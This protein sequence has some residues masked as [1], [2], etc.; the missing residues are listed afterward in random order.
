MEFPKIVLITKN[1]PWN[2]ALFSSGYLPPIPLLERGVHLKGL[3]KH[4]NGIRARRR[5]KIMLGNL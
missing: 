1:A 5:L 2:V 3:L 4:Q